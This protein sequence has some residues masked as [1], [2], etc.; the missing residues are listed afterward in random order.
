MHCCRGNTLKHYSACILHFFAI[1]WPTH[2]GNREISSREDWPWTQPMP[3]NIHFH[4]SRSCRIFNVTL[5]NRQKILEYCLFHICQFYHRWLTHH[6]RWVDIT[7][8]QGTTIFPQVPNPMK[9]IPQKYL[10]NLSE[11]AWGDDIDDHIDCKHPAV[12]RIE[13]HRLKEKI[14]LVYDLFFFF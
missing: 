7:F 9:N 10:V 3:S 6:S 4:L 5:Q 13:C 8:V 11:V 2:F 1:Y 14:Y 12:P